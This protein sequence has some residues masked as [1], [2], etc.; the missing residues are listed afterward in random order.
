MANQIV[1]II[2]EE[3]KEQY[4]RSSKNTEWMED[5]EVEELCLRRELETEVRTANFR[6]K[7]SKTEYKVPASDARVIKK[8]N[9]V[10]KAKAPKKAKGF[11]ASSDQQELNAEAQTVKSVTSTQQVKADTQSIAKAT[12]E[13]SKPR[14]NTGL[15]IGGAT[16]AAAAYLLLKE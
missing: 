10:R 11:H 2:K 13:A 5:G 4:M 8:K 15:I 1:A 3:F 6:F 9:L 16:A 12:I 14:S 7:Q